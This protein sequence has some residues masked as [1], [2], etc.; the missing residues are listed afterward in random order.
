MPALTREA[1]VSVVTEIVARAFDLPIARLTPD[2]DLR[3]VEGV[4]SVKVLRAIAMIEQH[5]GVE[6]EDEHV[7]KTT[8]I[9]ELA[10]VI[11]QT[12]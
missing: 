7:F 2:L 10:A 12:R 4:D 8:T 6:L 3:G 11:E 5:F 9:G 1:I